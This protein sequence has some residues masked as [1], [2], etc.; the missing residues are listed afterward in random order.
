MSQSLQFLIARWE[1]KAEQLE[2]SA[3]RYRSA[4]MEICGMALEKSRAYRACIQ[5]LTAPH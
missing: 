5:D 3:Q 2:E 1:A 4:M